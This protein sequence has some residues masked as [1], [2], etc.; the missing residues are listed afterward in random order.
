MFRPW[1]LNLVDCETK[2][3]QV[4]NLVSQERPHKQVYALNLTCAKIKDTV[5]YGMVWYDM[6]WHGM[7]GW[8]RVGY[9]MYGVVW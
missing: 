6:V 1:Q 2:Y 7:V 5:W 9:G 8:N 4:A 3:P